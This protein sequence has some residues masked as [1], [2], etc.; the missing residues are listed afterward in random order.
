MRSCGRVRK[1]KE[2]ARLCTGLEMRD[3]EI[4]FLL[5]QHPIPIAVMN[6]SNKTFLH[7]GC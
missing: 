4:L 7:S 2:V 1:G 3:A 6:S 5:V